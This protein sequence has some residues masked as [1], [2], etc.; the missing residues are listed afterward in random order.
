MGCGY[1]HDLL[2]GDL[3]FNGAL[4]V[5]LTAFANYPTDS[6]SAC[7]AVLTGSEQNHDLVRSCKALGAPIV[8]VCSGEALEWWKQGADSAAL[9]ERIPAIQIERFF[10]DHRFKFAPESVYRAKNWGRFRQEYQ[11]SFVDFGLMPLVEEQ[12]GQALGRL[13]EN[14]VGE[15]K[16][17]LGWSRISD[18]QGHWLL[19]SIF[20]LISAK[21]LRDKGVPNFKTVDL[22]DVRDVFTRLGR[23]YGTQ[24]ISTTPAPRLR[25]LEAISTAI[26][27]HSS[28]AIRPRKLLRMSRKHSHI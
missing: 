5:P 13:I 27:R 28:L 16:Q 25:A 17:A 6:R 3:Q 7:I 24:P 26:E 8:F 20:W 9:L 2:I 4:R 15:L 11:L 18:Q 14:N 21:I 19:S 1:H 12:V 22:S 23:H 10:H